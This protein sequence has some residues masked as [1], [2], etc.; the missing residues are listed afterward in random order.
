MSTSDKQYG[1]DDISYILRLANA[2]TKMDEDPKARAFL[3]RTR[4]ET[5]ELKGK[6]LYER[7]PFFQAVKGLV[8]DIPATET[9]ACCGFKDLKNPVLRDGA[10][11]GPE[12]ANH[13][14]GTCRA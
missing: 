7:S 1:T 8:E 4:R 10:I 12:C 2:R 5:D 9:C 3:M 11:V 14:L 13:P 6:P